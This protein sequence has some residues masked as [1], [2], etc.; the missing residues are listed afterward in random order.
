M[1]ITVLVCGTDGTQTVEEREVPDDW[2]TRAA[3]AG[4]EA[5]Q[6]PQNAP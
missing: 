5:K 4:K 2:F 6:S 3:K 1:T